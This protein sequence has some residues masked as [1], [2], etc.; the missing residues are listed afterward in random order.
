MKTIL[1]L[2]IMLAANMSA[3]EFC[4]LLR[5]GRVFDGAKAAIEQRQTLNAA[6][7]AHPEPFVRQ[8]PLVPAEVWINQPPQ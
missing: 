4:L 8:P 7:I 5:C 2:L 3:Q 6:Y 1:L